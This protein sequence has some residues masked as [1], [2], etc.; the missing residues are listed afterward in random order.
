M[1]VGDGLGIMIVDASGNMVARIKGGP[2]RVRQLAPGYSLRR[3][4]GGMGADWTYGGRATYDVSTPQELTGWEKYGGH[5]AY[6]VSSPHELT[7]DE[8]MFGLGQGRKVR[9]GWAKYGGHARFDPSMKPWEHPG[10]GAKVSVAAKALRGLGVDREAGGPGMSYGKLDKLALRS[11]TQ[12]LTL[13]N[14]QLSGDEGMF[15]PEGDE[16]ALF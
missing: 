6:N 3:G 1:V 14:Q 12:P 16:S 15:G 13:Y 2:G 10:R 11:T 8:G 5:A 4:T 7:G 9:R